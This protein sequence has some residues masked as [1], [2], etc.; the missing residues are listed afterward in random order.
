MQSVVAH[1]SPFGEP[2]E[3]AFARYA[4]T[5]VSGCLRNRDVV[6]ALAERQ[7]AFEAGRPSA[8]DQDAILRTPGGDVFRVPAATRF[9]HHRRVLRAADRYVRILARYAYIAADA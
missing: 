9:L 5:E 7:C 8:D 1:P 6:A 4:A 2:W 3:F